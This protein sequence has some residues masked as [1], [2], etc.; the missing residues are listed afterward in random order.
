MEVLLSTGA[1]PAMKNSQGQTVADL[2]I[3]EG[4]RDLV[5]QYEARQ[6]QKRAAAA[7]G[8]RGASEVAAAAAAG[9]KDKRP[10]SGPAAG[11][12][13]LVVA[14]AGRVSKAPEMPHFRKQRDPR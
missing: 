1:R 6:Q 12:G 14:A 3:G 2:C 4:A 10:G 7:G 9:G 8:G 5:E 13:K 11:G